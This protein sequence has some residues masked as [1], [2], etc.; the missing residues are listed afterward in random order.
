MEEE[1]SLCA[2]RQQAE[3]RLRRW[4]RRWSED[5]LLRRLTRLL[6]RF[7]LGMVLAGGRVLG[8][9]APFAVA[10]TAASGAGADGL[11]ALLG[12]LV[13][14]MM[15]ETAEEGL[16]R[17]AGCVL[18]FALAVA[19]GDTA[20]F[21]RGNAMPP[22]A[23]AL[24]ALTALV[25]L[26]AHGL[27]ASAAAALVG[28][29]A[30]CVLG[31]YAFRAGFALWDKP[32]FAP[33][34]LRRRLGLGA[35]ALAALTALSGKYLLG[36]V[37]IGRSL[38]ALAA[39]ASGYAAGAGAG[40]AVGLAGGL[41]MDLAL[42][43]GGHY[44]V[45]FALGGLLAGLLRGQGRACAAG[46]FA[47]G[48]GAVTLWHWESFQGASVVY[49]MLL[50]GVGFFLL[51][52]S[53]LE[54]LKLLLGAGET[55]AEG[56]EKLEAAR[57]RLREAAE[58]FSAVVTAMRGAFPRPNGAEEPEA[59]VDETARRVCAHCG[60]RE[61]CWQREYEDTHDLL[62]AALRDILNTG[63]VEA[64]AFPQR[65][66][67]RCCRF[68]RFLSTAEDQWRDYLLRRQLARRLAESRA[69]LREQ[70]GAM[71]AALEEAAEVLARP[72][73]ADAARTAKLRQF[74]LGREMRC[75]GRV[76][77]DRRGRMCL[78]LTGEDAAALADEAGQE[79]LSALL[80]VPLSQVERGEESVVYRQ[81]EPLRVTAALAGDAKAG[82]ALSADAG[83]WFKGNDGLCRILLCDG[84]GSGA[85][86]RR[87]SQATL[88]I[89]EKLLRAGIR[90]ETALKTVDQ[91]L[92]LRSE[93][94]GGFVALDLLELDLF[95][96]QSVLYKLG[97][98][99]SY[100]KRG[101]TV[102]KLEGDTPPAG[103][104][105]DEHRP[106]RVCFRLSPGDSLL[107]ITDGV[108]GGEGDEW[109]RRE[110]SAFDLDSPAEFAKRV[111]LHSGDRTDDRT[112]L[113]VRVGC[114][115]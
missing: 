75:G 8:G 107:L 35:M 90:A 33:A 62:S 41:T 56:G 94:S 53:R 1:K 45:A 110:L 2:E 79:S 38:C 49:E 115:E 7:V 61:R 81:S 88:E 92:A 59:V 84:M 6:A 109:L 29:T 9:G 73:T 82:E 19:F 89:L 63:R 23:G 44:A 77:F 34:P 101:G 31:V 69:V 78:A 5:R 65:F 15:E 74:L 104:D 40:A 97:S 37:N 55:P 76:Y 103:V 12:A 10:F 85:E 46:A 26:P 4:A 14:Y 111:A 50:V 105:L 22:A 106:T 21:R 30:F 57:G 64:A 99:A 28:E 48:W 70:Y 67:D 18:V 100:L 91:A 20:L 60:M 13:G 68:S 108:L 93:G 17:G 11:M 52:Q 42:G 47:I 80:D 95:T 102:V 25:S 71:A 39:L 32:P 113:A 66:R 43:S 36:A 96:G 114:G 87:D 24:N 54:R 58:G 83:V 3:N 27:T 51:R 72:E 112:A 86:A 16:R 98:P